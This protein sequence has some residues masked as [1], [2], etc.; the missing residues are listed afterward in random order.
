V[1]QVLVFAAI[2]S[3]A[4][5]VGG[6]KKHA[7]NPDNA[8]KPAVATPEGSAEPAPEAEPEAQEPGEPEAPAEAAPIDN[9]E[10]QPPVK[11]KPDPAV[12]AKFAK[13]IP[14]VVNTATDFDYRQTEDAWFKVTVET[15][16]PAV[17]RVG[18]LT[19]WGTAVEVY[20][21]TGAKFSP[22]PFR[23]NRPSGWHG[24]V[25]PGVYYIRL[26]T[27]PDEERGDQNAGMKMSPEELAARARVAGKTPSLTDLG[28]RPAMLV[29][30]DPPGPGETPRRAAQLGLDYLE[31]DSPAWQNKFACTGC[32]LQSQTLMGMAL[33]KKN[34]YKVQ[35]RA[36]LALG[37]FVA[38]Q[39][40]QDV[41]EEK[42]NLFNVM[43][44]RYYAS[45]FTPTRNDQLVPAVEGL[46]DD[47]PEDFHFD[48]GDHPPIQNGMI[49]GTAMA[50]GVLA[51]SLRSASAP[52]KAKLQPALDKTYAY[53]KSMQPKSVQDHVLKIMAAV[54]A[55]AKP[56]ALAK[57]AT[58][59]VAL[60]VK[61]GGFPEVG[62]VDSNAYGT[63]QALYGLKLAG[64]STEAPAFKAG[65]KWLV[66]HQLWN[67]TWPLMA[68]ECTSDI[69][70]TMW[71]VIGLAGSLE[72]SLPVRVTAVARDAKGH[73][74]SDLK[75]EDFAITE[76]GAPQ[77]ILQ[78]KRD[79]GDRS[80]VLIIDTSGSI[81]AALP[82]VVQAATS[83]LT[84]LGPKDRVALEQFSSRVKPPQPFTTD[85]D[86]V[87]A[88]LKLLKAAG[89]TAL[90]DSISA[91]LTH[92]KDSP[93]PRAIVLLTDGKDEDASGKHAGSKATLSATLAR[94][95]EEGTPL[96]ALGLGAGVEKDVLTRL[97]GA[98]GGRAFFA[99]T[100][101][102]L[103]AVY[104]ELAGA[105]KS[106]YILVYNSTKPAADNAWRKIDVKVARPTVTVEGTPGYTATR[107]LV[108]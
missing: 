45:A 69:A 30:V 108:Q 3:M 35:D 9:A 67:G 42:K 21:P 57:A 70:H 58:A 98:S 83:F 27:L 60:Q 66:D 49:T 82:G 63:G 10:L 54:D 23:E 52:Q 31:I 26:R 94:L 93:E 106:Q 105:L 86:G 44:L 15:T 18:G 74:V 20:D 29:M 72:S 89:G 68:T 55:G 5:V 85:R 40:E 16:E 104:R 53:L 95:K 102:D 62:K 71:A 46:V 101:K 36:A 78:F 14:L 64:Y 12:V 76:D 65:V 92:V 73:Y 8:P 2:V 7:A 4:V 1:K 97:A 90:Y 41:G 6:C 32:H 48:S 19:T 79:V 96:F 24:K 25:P 37:E 91:A 88:Q 100:E 56:D 51:E 11:D 38:Y 34:G 81:K 77:T 61:D 43:A 22:G 13:A 28:S 47:P 59:L 84:L 50:V 80:I 33:A 99:P 75:K 17:L 87:A 103:D 107:D 39:F